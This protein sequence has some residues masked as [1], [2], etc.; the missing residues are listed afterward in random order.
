MKKL[1]ATPLFIFVLLIGSFSNKASAYS[2]YVDHYSFD[3]PNGWEEIQKSVIDKFMDEVA[4]KTSGKRIEFVS[5]FQLTGNENFKYPYILVQDH[6]GDTPSFSQLEKALNSDSLQKKVDQKTAEYSELLNNATTDRPFVDKERNIIFMNIELD[7]TNVGKVNGLIVMFFGENKITQ[8]NFYSTKSEYSEWLPVFNSIV[9][10][11]KYDDGFIY[12]PVEAE[13]NDTLSIFNGVMEKGVSGAIAGGFLGI[14]ASIIGWIFVKRN[15]NGSSN[16]KNIIK[17]EKHEQHDKKYDVTLKVSDQELIDL[18]SKSW[19][20]FLKVLYVI[21]FCLSFLYLLSVGDLVKK[22][23]Y[24][25]SIFINCS[26]YHN[27]EEEKKFPESGFGRIGAMQHGMDYEL[28]RKIAKSCDERSFGINL[29]ID[30]G[31]TFKF[32]L[33]FVLIVVIFES[34]RQVG[35]YIFLGKIYHHPWTMRLIQFWK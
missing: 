13:K 12:N 27:F 10:S 30:F 3:L 7:V 23:F 8:L 35:Y 31:N 28:S 18:R 5:G 16:R 32:V 15:K 19:Y 21:G 26:D 29:K 6:K 24:G 25:K 17:E 2:D 14:L 9:D 33:Y 11:F 34:L 20:R 1:F 22:V 4:G